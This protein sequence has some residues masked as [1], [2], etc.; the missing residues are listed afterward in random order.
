MAEKQRI[1]CV[2]I[3]K[4]LAILVVVVTHLVSSQAASDFITRFFGGLMGVFFMLSSYFYKPGKG[5]LNNVRK[6]FFQIIIPFLV[7]NLA[8]VVLC[9]IYESIKCPE[10]GFL[11]YLQAYWKRIIDSGSLSVIQSAGGPPRGVR[12]GSIATMAIV[13]SWFLNRMFFSELIFFAIADWALK[14]V[15]RLAASIFALLTVTVLYYQFVPVHAPLMLDN[16]F[17]IAAIMLFGAYMRQIDLATF[18][19]QRKWDRKKIIVTAVFAALYIAAGFFLT[20]FFG[21]GL[22]MGQF[23]T[24]GSLSVYIWFLCQVIFFYTMLFLGTLIAHVPFL[25]APLKLIGRH[26]LMILLFHMFFGSVVKTVLA[27]AFGCESAPVWVSIAGVVLSVLFSL[28]LSLL[29]DRAKTCLA[30]RKEAK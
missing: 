14:D 16:C 20:D 4:G 10:Y 2:D 1:Q 24:A 26:T 8:V 6:R 5:Y 22:I 3:V 27:F 13:P 15:R 30:A 11:S 29:R 17:A 7:Y 23:G 28:C 25:S 21:K 18:I 12:A 9:W 19:E